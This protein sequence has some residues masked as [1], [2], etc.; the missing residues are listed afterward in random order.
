LIDNCTA[1]ESENLLLVGTAKKEIFDNYY[2]IV[3]DLCDYAAEKKVK[4]NLKPHGGLNATG[5]QCAEIVKL[6]NHKNFTLWYDPGN[7]FYYSDGKIDPVQDAPSVDGLVSGM[8]VKDFLLPK[9]VLVTPGSGMVDFPEVMNRL[10]KGGFNG[11]PLVVECL[12]PG[13]LPEILT[14]A[15]KTSKFLQELVSVQ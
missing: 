6:V 13:T 9:N 14:E 7:I 5:P 1:C 10:I 11:G 8:C 3:K 12:K 4:I 15:K 2:N